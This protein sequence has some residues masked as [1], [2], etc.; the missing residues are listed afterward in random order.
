[1]YN[2]RKRELQVENLMPV[3]KRISSKNVTIRNLINEK[4]GELIRQKLKIEFDNW[5]EVKKLWQLSV[6][7]RRNLIIQN[8]T[9]KV[10][11]DWSTYKFPLGYTLVSNCKS[12]I[13]PNIK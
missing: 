4:D 8:S 7:T 2:N 1:M 10:I 9:E 3:K 5:D 11:E 6:H 13:S 12:I